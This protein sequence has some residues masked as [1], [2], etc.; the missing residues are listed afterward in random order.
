MVDEAHIDANQSD[1]LSDSGD[2][3]ARMIKANQ[4]LEQSVRVLN[5]KMSGDYLFAGANTG[6]KP[7]VVHRYETGDPLLDG[8]GVADFAAWIPASGCC[9]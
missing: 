9:K 1:G 6:E 7:F 3:T 2:Y 4:Q 8:S 5:A